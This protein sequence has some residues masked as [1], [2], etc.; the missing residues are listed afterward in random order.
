MSKSYSYRIY[1]YENNEINIIKISD[2]CSFNQERFLSKIKFSSEKAAMDFICQIIYLST[3]DFS[4]EIFVS[5]ISIRIVFQNRKQQI[6]CSMQLRFH[7]AHRHFHFGCNFFVAIFFVIAQ[8]NQLAIFR[9]Q[10]FNRSF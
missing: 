4:H 1:L 10:F 5:K 9:V 8:L 7:S 6:F 2:E 3:Y